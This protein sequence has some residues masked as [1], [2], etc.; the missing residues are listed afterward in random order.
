MMKNKIEILAP[1]G[2]MDSVVAAVR[3]G[4]DA[5]YVGAKQF[6]A[7]AHAAN[8]DISE[9]RECTAYCHIRGVKVYLAL[10][11]VIFDDEIEDALGLLK[12]A[13]RADIDAV[14]IQ[15]MGLVSLC[16]EAIP[17]LRLHASTQMTVHTPYGAKAL[18]ELGFSRVVL[19][20][21]L[22]LEE[23]REIREAVPQVELE[24]FVHGAL[25]MCV[26]GQCYFSA[27]L[28]GRSANRGMCAQPCR[29]PIRFGEND[30]ALSL[31]DN[32]AIEYLNE[33][34]EIGVVSAKIEGRMKRPEYVATAVSACREKRDS[35][36]VSPK[37]EERL[38][39]V[40]SRSGF[41]DGYIAGKI[42]ESM[43]G[44]RKREDV[45]SAEPKLLR[46]I[47]NG[48]KDE[49]KSVGVEMTLYARAGETARLSVTD[50]EHE[51][52]AESDAHAEAAIKVA[53]TEEK[54]AQS[55]QKTGNTPYIVKEIRCD[56]G[57]NVSLSAAALNALRRDAL[58]QLDAVRA[59]RH[60]YEIHEIDLSLSGEEVIDTAPRAV[61]CSLDI[62]REM[63]D[64]KMI[65]AEI[66]AMD[67]EK[68]AAL[69]RK[70]VA[71]GVEIPRVMFG[72]ESEI[73]EKL[74]HLYALGVR[75]AMAH[76]IGAVY[77]ARQRGMRVHAGFGLNITNSYALDFYRSM[78][79]ESAELSVE[80]SEKRIE[81]LFKCIPVGIFAGGHMPMMITR[82]APA[83]SNESCKNNDILQDRKGERFL[84][85]RHNGAYEIMNGVPFYV[86]SGTY[87]F[88]NRVFN[89]LHFFVDNS[90]ENTEKILRFFS[91][92]Q[93]PNR[94]TRGMYSK[95]VKKF[96]IQ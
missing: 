12:A 47:R 87:P 32:S 94:F 45:V 44:Y 22:S 82:N 33:L 39:S 5:V 20:R 63:I 10:N 86:P 75:D 85:K 53:L 15:D 19:S 29:L 41:T 46:E 67:D 69:L 56:I 70:G 18:W 60:N 31:K 24:V 34:E 36:M 65:F 48:Y 73:N 89:C 16:R 8:F 77:M 80:L 59:V 90:V 30:H 55:L 38:R 26:S 96:T 74:G 11:T 76:N 28:G 25:C 57:E 84:I 78:G 2:G 66:G 13:A 95:G 4:A 43:F 35:G 92:N 6:S 68:I 23:I 62:P 83:G 21:E 79:V 88:Q 14:I 27:M 81:R 54:A 64:F 93:A 42:G 71:L 1:A 49:R 61:G 40:F 7:R 72:T 17:G 3:S 52:K 58:E 51:I 50:G 9:L 37:T 91:E